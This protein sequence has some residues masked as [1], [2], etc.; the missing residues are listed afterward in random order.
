MKNTA[1]RTIATA[2]LAI[3]LAGCGAGSGGSADHA[4]TG[5]QYGMAAQVYCRRGGHRRGTPRAGTKTENQLH[6]VVGLS[7]RHICG[8]IC[9]GFVIF[10]DYYG[11]LQE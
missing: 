2:A 8:S 3:A 4:R 9:A 6:P 10:R 11:Y 7:G 5:A 1:L